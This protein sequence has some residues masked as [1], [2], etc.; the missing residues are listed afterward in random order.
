MLYVLATFLT[1]SAVCTERKR[2]VHLASWSDLGDWLVSETEGS[3]WAV[4]Q[5]L[6]ST[7]VWCNPLELCKSPRTAAALCLEVA[8]ISA[9]SK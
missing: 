3:L 6:L 8:K 7:S 5:V 1:A 2:I 9:K 4:D